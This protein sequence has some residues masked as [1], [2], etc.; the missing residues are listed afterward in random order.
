MSTITING[1][2]YVGNS[3]TVRNNVVY[4]DGKLADEAKGKDSILEVHLVGNLDKLECDGSVQL[5]GNAGRIAA[6]GSV[7]C[8]GDVTGNIAAGGSINC[9]SVSGHCSAGGSINRR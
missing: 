9:G 3:I 1:K 6:G 2:T 7:D 8:K 4:I 5:T